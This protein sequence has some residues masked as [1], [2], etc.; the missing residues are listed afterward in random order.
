MFEKL[1]KRFYI[2]GILATI[3]IPM[4]KLASVTRPSSKILRIR[5]EDA[6][7]KSIE[8]Q[9]SREACIAQ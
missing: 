5:S 4:N 7:G 8:L 2:V 3:L 6:Y 1:H 9:L